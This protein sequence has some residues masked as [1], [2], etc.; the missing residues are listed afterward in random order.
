MV[1]PYMVRGATDGSFFRQKG[2]A[3]Y[4]A[5][6]YLREDKESRAHGNDERI[7]VESLGSGANLLRQIV[8]KVSQISG[9]QLA[10]PATAP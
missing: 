5:P 7:S 9:D 2:M 6:L 10:V 1:I 8:M 3:V 4:G